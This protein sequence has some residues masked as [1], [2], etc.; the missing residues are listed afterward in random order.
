MDIETVMKMGCWDEGVEAGVKRWMER[1]G[2]VDGCGGE[3]EVWN[4]GWRGR[5]QTMKKTDG[6]M[7]WRDE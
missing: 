4:E 7:W 2:G 3:V 5:R 1:C 6:W